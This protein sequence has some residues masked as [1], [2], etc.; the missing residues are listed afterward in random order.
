MTMLTQLLGEC[1]SKTT[2]IE[3]WT[4]CEKCQTDWTPILKIKRASG[5]L[6][7]DVSVFP[8]EHY[9]NPNSIV[10]VD[11]APKRAYIAVGDAQ[12]SNYYPHG[13][14]TGKLGKRATL[15]GYWIQALATKGFDAIGTYTTLLKN[16]FYTHFR[17]TLCGENMN[18]EDT[19]KAW[20]LS[21]PDYPQAPSANAKGIAIGALYIK[22]LKKCRT[23]AKPIDGLAALVD[24]DP[25]TPPIKPIWQTFASEEAYTSWTQQEVF[26]FRQIPIKS[27]LKRTLRASKNIKR[28]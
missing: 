13:T 9:Y 5:A 8:T 25:L 12:V 20:A 23:P 6:E 27:Q 21:K 11:Q 10:V 24:W 4:D 18:L 7:A 14:S 3:K 17:E 26:A 28:A 2:C 15:I 16:K 1:N 19:W 22:A